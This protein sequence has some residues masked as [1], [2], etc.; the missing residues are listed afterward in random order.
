MTTNQKI[1]KNKLRLL[2]LA[3]MLGSVAEEPRNTPRRA[4][5]DAE[6]SVQAQNCAL[7][8]IDGRIP[9]LDS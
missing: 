2:N 7:M 3:Q 6:Y 4:G 5:P 1:I 8:P 9:I